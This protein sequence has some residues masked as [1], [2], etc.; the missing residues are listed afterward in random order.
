[1]SGNVGLFLSLSG[2]A[3]E[4]NPSL[5]FSAE[6]QGHFPATMTRSIISEVQKNNLTKNV[7]VQMAARELA[8]IQLVSEPVSQKGEYQVK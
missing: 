3:E 6:N 1:M 4:L 8:H 7:Q 2:P 5:Y